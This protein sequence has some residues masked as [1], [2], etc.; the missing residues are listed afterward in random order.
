MTSASLIGAW[1]LADSLGILL[2]KTTHAGS[3]FPHL[4]P[5]QRVHGDLG[6]K[7]QPWLYGDTAEAAATKAI[8]LRYRLLPYIYSYERV[9]NETGIGV[10]RPALLDLS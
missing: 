10:V 4:F 9:A 1:I 2:L 5:V 6:E 3:N 7:R 8:Q